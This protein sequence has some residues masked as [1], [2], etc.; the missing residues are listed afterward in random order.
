MDYICFKFSTM[1]CKKDC[2]EAVVST[3]SDII[4]K[5]GFTSFYPLFVILTDRFGNKTQRLFTTNSDGDLVIEKDNLPAGFLEIPQL[6]NI[7]LRD[8]SN[9]LQPVLFDFGGEPYSCIQAESVSMDLAEGDTSA[10]NV[11][12]FTEASD[13]VDAGMLLPVES[14]FTIALL[15]GKTLEYISFKNLLPLTVKIGTTAG[16]SD[17]MAETTITDNQPQVLMHSANGNETLYVEGILPGTIVKI[18][19]S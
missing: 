10:V 14:N 9:Y 18:K 3:C 12:Q 5:A 8:G 11:I 1:A 15:D 17:V 2:Y 7:E 6:L 19:K 16:G 4:I 13:P